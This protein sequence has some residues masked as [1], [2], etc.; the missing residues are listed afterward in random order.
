M[1]H[2]A[3]WITYKSSL[4]KDQVDKLAKRIKGNDFSLMSPYDAQDTPISLQTWGYQL[5]VSDASDPRIDAFIKALRQV[6]ARE[7]GATCSS[8]NMIT[9]TGTIPHDLGKDAPSQPAGQPAP[10]GT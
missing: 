10:A 4:P 8:D 6:S 5:K 1:E 9:E 3:V 7:P 2:G